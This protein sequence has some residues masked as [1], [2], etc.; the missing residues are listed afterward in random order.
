MGSIL[1]S[2]QI[3][4]GCPPQPAFVGDELEAVN[5]LGDRIHIK[6][7]SLKQDVSKVTVTGKD[8]AFKIEYD[9][10]IIIRF[11]G[12]SI[13]NITGKKARPVV[14]TFK[15]GSKVKIVPAEYD[16]DGAMSSSKLFRMA[17]A[18]ATVE[19]SANGIVATVK[20]LENPKKGGMLSGLWSKP[21]EIKK[22]DLNRFAVEIKKGASVIAKGSGR[23]TSYLEIDGKCYWRVT[24]PVPAWDFDHSDVTK[25]MSEETRTLK[26][27]IKQK[28][29]AEAQT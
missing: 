19:D 14:I 17:N 1:S 15:D 24:D 6:H 29:F 8:G 2:V 9:W 18:T 23:Y 22:S 25:K 26:Q 11:R 3:Q 27:L 4:K 10:E 20:Y 28:K 7:E 16:V 5:E 13:S 12:L 21:A